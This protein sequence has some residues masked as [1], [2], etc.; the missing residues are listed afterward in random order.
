MAHNNS[1]AVLVIVTVMTV[2]AGFVVAIIAVLGD[3]ALLPAGTWR[4][5]ESEHDK[6]ID[7]IL[8]HAWLF[9]AYLVA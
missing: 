1:D 9:R 8:T 6:S 3:P 2:F 4:A 7:A 5:A